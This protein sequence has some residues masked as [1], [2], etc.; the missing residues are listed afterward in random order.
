VPLTAEEV[1]LLADRVASKIAR[2]VLLALGMSTAT[3]GAATPPAFIRRLTVEEFAVCVEMC[4]E[5]VRRKIRSRYIPKEA[6]GGPP[7]K[8]DAGALAKF[9]VS[10]ELAIARLSAWR[11]QSLSPAAQRSAG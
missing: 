5:V 2:H 4:P 7:Y 11:T 9:G 1:E 10:R 3:P 8:I 6:V